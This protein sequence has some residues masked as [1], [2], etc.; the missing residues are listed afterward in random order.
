MSGAKRYRLNRDIPAT[1]LAFLPDVVVSAADYSSLEK[2]ADTI[3][4]WYSNA[5]DNIRELQAERDK[6]AKAMQLVNGRLGIFIE[7]DAHMQVHSL[8]A[9]K[10]II[11]RAMQECGL[12]IE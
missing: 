4:G 6:L 5:L 3:A 12:P 1:A 10:G 11:D 8:E 9:L 7:D 2:R